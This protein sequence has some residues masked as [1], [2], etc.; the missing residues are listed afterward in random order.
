MHKKCDFIEVKK[1][2]W[3]SIIIIRRMYAIGKHGL[4]LFCIA[5]VYGV[6]FKHYEACITAVISY[7]QDWLT[8]LTIFMNYICMIKA[9]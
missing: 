4:A 3:P 1:F 8:E 9:H 7:T 5:K 2:S 6:V